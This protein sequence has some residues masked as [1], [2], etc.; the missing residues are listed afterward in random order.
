MCADLP[1]P[2]LPQTA[3]FCSKD[4]DRANSASLQLLPC[5][6]LTASARQESAAQATKPSRQGGDLEMLVCGGPSLE[7]GCGEQLPP[8]WGV[9]GEKR[10][11]TQPRRA[12]SRGFQGPV[13]GDCGS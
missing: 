4:T 13:A 9:L 7:P 2:V 6:P 11:H 12:K 8:S 10:F 5:L 1:G 3:N